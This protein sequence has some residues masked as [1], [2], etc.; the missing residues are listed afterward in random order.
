MIEMEMKKI[1]GLMGLLAA[2]G[3]GMMAFSL[4]GIVG[5]VVLSSSSVQNPSGQQI[6]YGSMVCVYHNNEEVYCSP[7]TLTDIGKNLT[8]D[9]LTGGEAAA[10]NYIAVG[11]GTPVNASTVFLEND[12]DECGLE[13]T[14]D[15]SAVDL[16]DNGNW[17]YSVMFTSTCNG[18]K[19]NTT[20]LYNN[21]AASQEN[22]SFAGDTFGSAVTLQSSDQLN[23]TW[24]VF[25]T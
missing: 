3:V 11:N 2:V 20:V 13:R 25:V 9:R 16:D 8:R 5:N 12:I 24:Y 15:T 14:Q 17:S 10:M 4:G 6:E 18:I 21:S 23:V 1:I 22:T 7:N 19:V